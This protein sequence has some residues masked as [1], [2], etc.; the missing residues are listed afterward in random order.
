MPC[1]R[2]T[3]QPRA[4]LGQQGAGTGRWVRGLWRHPRQ[5]LREPGQLPGKEIF[6]PLVGVLTS[7][8]EGMLSNASSPAQGLAATT[9]TRHAWF[10]QDAA[11]RG[12]T[13][14]QDTCVRMSGMCEVLGDITMESVYLETGHH[15]QTRHMCD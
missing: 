13:M 12:L 7:S 11:G 5:D 10:A 4:V 2:K 3:E 6:T 8:R 1:S 14:D 9:T 15:A